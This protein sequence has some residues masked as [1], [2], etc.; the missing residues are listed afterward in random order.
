[1][2]G[3][4]TA[5]KSKKLESRK[6]QGLSVVLLVSLLIL[7]MMF[8]LG[9]CA[10]DKNGMEQENNVAES[11]EDASGEETFLTEEGLAARESEEDVSAADGQERGQDI[12]EPADFEDDQENIQEDNPENNISGEEPGVS[13]AWLNADGTLAGTPLERHG[14][15]H[16][17]GTLLVDES[18]NSVV[19]RGVSTHGLSWFPEYANADAFRSMRDEWGI[20]IVRLAMYSAEYNGYCTGDENNRRRLKQK[21]YDSVQAATD[22]GLYVIVDWH[23]LGDQNPLLY[24][25]QAAAF[26]EECTGRLGNQK[27]VIYEICNEPNGNATWQDVKTYAERII[28]IIRA[29]APDA[30]II[31]GTPTWS[32][33]V[34]RALNDPVTGYDDLLYALHFYANTHRDDLRNRLETAVTNGLPVFVSEFGICDASGNGGVNTEQADIW[35]E[36]L[37]RYGISSCIW[38]LTNKDESASLIRADCSKLSGWSY[39]ELSASGQWFVDWLAA[40]AGYEFFNADIPYNGNNLLGGNGNQG[41]SS[42][43][44]QSGNGASSGNGNSGGQN[45]F[46]QGDSTGT[47][48]ASAEIDGFKITVS[49]TNSWESN[50]SYY[51]QCSVALTNQGSSDINGWQCEISLDCDMNL[52]QFWC[53]Q[54][55][56]N[57][58][59]LRIRPESYNSVIAAGA[60]YGDVG[61]IFYTTK[62]PG[63]MQAALT[64]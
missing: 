60:E 44:N 57:G 3:H 23:V 28:P 5:D 26:F 55:E 21:I 34:D 22:L 45:G 19:L 14:R 7:S 49:V 1:M 43:S 29:N 18:G 13:T 37:Q 64:R 56:V 41:G 35:M 12:Q 10:S 39:N 62:K 2:N 36:L 20:N 30:L 47:L 38:S 61:F 59:T 27:N 42:Q 31:I 54:F 48:G 50:G 32:Q 8:C 52:D 63:S 58:T 6:Q 51:Y 24:Q 16:V 40:H 33:E 4:N 53:G 11:E 17:S 46:S 15:L 25:D 9:G